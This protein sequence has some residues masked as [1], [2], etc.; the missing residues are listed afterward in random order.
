MKKIKLL[1]WN[2]QLYE[3]GNRENKTI[4]QGKEQYNKIKHDI[5]N[6]LNIE[7]NQKSIAVLQEIPYKIKNG[8]KWEF[9]PIFTQF[10][11]DFPTE[12]YDLL[13]LADTVQKKYWHIKM[14]VVIA[15]KD[16]IEAVKFKD[17]SN[18]YTPF[19]IKDLKKGRVLALHA[20]ANAPFETR[21]WLNEN[22]EFKPDIIIGDFNAGNYRKAEAEKDAEIAANR[23]NYQLLSDGYLDLCNGKCTTR[24]NTQIDHILI[25]NIADKP[26]FRYENVY[27]DTDNNKS[28]HYPIYCDIIID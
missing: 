28:D 5:E 12:K 16:T 1:T 3:Y 26:I 2:T 14:I 19:V 24:Y 13:Y 22:S 6:H 4:E 10:I 7:E 9:N 21:Q 15:T 17:E 23:H 25:K 27:V 8:C 18:I 20:H 11:K